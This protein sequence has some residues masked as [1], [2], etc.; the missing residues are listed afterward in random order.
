MPLILTAEFGPPRLDWVLSLKEAWRRHGGRWTK[1]K[2]MIIEERGAQCGICG[3]EKGPLHAHEEWEHAD[4]AGSG[5][6]DTHIQQALAVR[7]AQELHLPALMNSIR[8]EARPF[9]YSD[10]AA[11][12]CQADSSSARGYQTALP[13]VPRLQTF[14]R[15]Q[16]HAPLVLGERSLA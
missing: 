2:K 5:L 8:G 1:L 6:D 12:M 10:S 11:S 7:Q 13:T 14:L 3:S 4:A 9:C 15:S 16:I